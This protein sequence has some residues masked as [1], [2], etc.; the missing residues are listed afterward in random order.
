MFVNIAI[1]L[2]ALSNSELNYLYYLDKNRPFN[3]YFWMSSVGVF[4]EDLPQLIL[5]L[6]YSIMSTQIF[7][8]KVKVIQWVSI[9]FSIWKLTTC[10]LLKYLIR[11]KTTPAWM[12]KADFASSVFE[13]GFEFIPKSI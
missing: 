7:G 4:V 12:E 11:D 5:Q 10:L 2:V 8:Q 1:P 9:G 3:E 13:K 6:V